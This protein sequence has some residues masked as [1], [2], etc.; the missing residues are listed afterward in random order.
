MTT[1]FTAD[2]LASLGLSTQVLGEVTEINLAFDEG[3]AHGFAGAESLDISNFVQA[4]EEIPIHAPAAEVMEFILANFSDWPELIMIDPPD[5]SFRPRAAQDGLKMW[6]GDEEFYLDLSTH[7]LP[8]ALLNERGE[9]LIFARDDDKLL[10]AQVLQLPEELAKPFTVQPPLKAWLEHSED[11]WLIEQTR[12]KQA[13]EDPWHNFVAAGLFHRFWRA[14]SA[15]D[16]AELVKRLLAG[17]PTPEMNRAVE[18]LKG[19][20]PGT[21]DRLVNY[22]RLIIEDLE[23]TLQKLT[24]RLGA[25]EHI[26][27]AEILD[28]AHQRD[29]IECALVLLNA[30]DRFDELKEEIWALDAPG[31]ALMKSLQDEIL[32]DSDERLRRAIA[33]TPESWW[34]L[35][36]EPN[37]SEGY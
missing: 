29:D 10:L 18:W 37:L 22:T 28:L 14:D 2:L 19:I 32:L 30:A 17:E 15:Q 25:G 11:H 8:Q 4:R 1:P 26:L 35:L 33:C 12:L 20:E 36:A 16:R 34:T 21:L 31:E 7:T 24:D 27:R 13:L 3:A 23:Q 6:E 5:M 9:G